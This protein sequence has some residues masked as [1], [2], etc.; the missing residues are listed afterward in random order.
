[1][2]T[3]RRILIKQGLWLVASLCAAT[4]AAAQTRV[5][6]PAGSVILV[7]TNEPLVSNTAQVGQTFETTVLDL[8]SVNGYAVIP[9]GSR[10]RGVVSYVQP[11]TRQRS[12]VMH[13]TFDRL[14]LANGA[15]VAIAGKLT[16]TDSTERRQIDARSDSR[17]VLVGERGGIGAMIA[18]AGSSSSSAGSILGALGNM[19][20]EGTNVNVPANTQL[21]VQLERAVTLS[22]RG[23]AN[24]SDPSTIYTEGERIRAAQQVLS[25]RAYYRGSTNGVLD[26]ATR[27]AIFEFQIDNNITPTGNLDGRTAAALGIT[28][29]GT[30]GGTTGG[31]VLSARDA[32]LMRRAAQAVQS[33][34]RQMLAISTEGRLNQGRAYSQADLELYF[35]LSAFADN[36]SLY[37]QLVTAGSTGEGP[38]A[39]GVALVNA[40]RRVDT[41][42][43][44]ARTTGQIQNNWQTIRQQLT[45]LDP[46][47]R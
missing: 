28:G 23:N 17:V 11:A 37:E 2:H 12:G 46:N 45:R 4:A 47:Y 40:A 42:L 13:V 5:A 29:G 33:R 34:E 39:A 25:R 24:A 19:L 6:V 3:G 14:T 1:M 44:Q 30:T 9:A 43:Q 18:G 32:S 35:A 8:L 16:S 26:N 31:N 10:I 41:A 21:A 20:S 27:R 15:S 7:R 36:A 38:V 22:G